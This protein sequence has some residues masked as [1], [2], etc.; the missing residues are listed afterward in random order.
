MPRRGAWHHQTVGP[1]DGVEL[2]K[3]LPVEAQA[4]LKGGF[5]SEAGT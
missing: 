4:D 3:R 1:L 5:P 2:S